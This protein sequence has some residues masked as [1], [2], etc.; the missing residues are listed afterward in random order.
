[1]MH[2]EISVADAFF[3]SL[4]RW[5]L[6][7]LLTVVG[8]VLAWTFH[9]LQPPVYE[10]VATFSVVIDLP[11]N[12]PA[13]DEREQDQAIGVFKALL[14]A[15]PVVENVRTAAQARGIPLEALA[16][17]RR[18]FAERRQSQIDL[19]VRHE[20]PQTA[21][22]IANLWADQAYAVM[23]EAYGHALQAYTLGQ[24][25]QSLVQCIQ[26]ESPAPGSLCALESL[27]ALE[28]RLQ[29]VEAER[30]AELL[31]S[32]AL[33]PT[34]VFEFSQRAE[35]PQAPVAYPAAALLLA[36]ALIGC[37]SGIVLA[38][39]PWPGAKNGKR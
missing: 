16:L 12:I 27:D 4:R 37:V 28:A 24:Y 17:N 11:E 34:L 8:G 38:V 22:A 14:I 39:L 23:V 10:A 30:Q 33:L 18:V 32:Q 13:L 25:Q 20:D 29:Q 35:P 6:V 3:R 31:A 7:A 5:W 2:H 1:M 15:T 9:A 19:I 36:G 21:A 26:A